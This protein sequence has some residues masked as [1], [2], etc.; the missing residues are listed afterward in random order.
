MLLRTD[1]TTPAFG[2][3]PTRKLFDLNS[4]RRPGC[5]IGDHPTVAKIGG[6]EYQAI[7]FVIT[8]QR[9]VAGRSPFRLHSHT[10]VRF[11]QFRLLLLSRKRND[12]AR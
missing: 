8:A 1:V 12:A 9:S 11:R 2:A 10:A 6:T 5:F 4:R 3:G 7:E